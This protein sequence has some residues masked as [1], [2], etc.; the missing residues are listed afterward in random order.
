M[1]IAFSLKRHA[2]NYSTLHH[3]DIAARVA[4]LD[5]RLIKPCVIYG[6]TNGEEFHNGVQDYEAMGF[7]FCDSLLDLFDPDANK[8]FFFL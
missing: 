5:P 7:H 2:S 1:E 3:S 8:V 4:P 6:F